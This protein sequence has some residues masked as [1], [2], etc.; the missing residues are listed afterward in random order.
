M[1]S[2]PSQGRGDD[3]EPSQNP[4]GLGRW[5]PIKRLD[6]EPAVYGLGL[7]LHAALMDDPFYFTAACTSEIS[8][9]MPGPMVE[10]IE[11]FFR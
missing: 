2:R 8:S 10:E 7:Y 9:K 6:D 4:W 5:F 3:E 11:I 1:V